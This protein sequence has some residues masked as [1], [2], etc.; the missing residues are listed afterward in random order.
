LTSKPVVTTFRVHI[1]SNQR[2][3]IGVNT[4]YTI[5]DKAVGN[6]VGKLRC[7]EKLIVV[8]HTVAYP[9]PD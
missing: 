8:Y 1:L 9:Q 6:Q 7:N 3:Y 5:R 2:K 4:T